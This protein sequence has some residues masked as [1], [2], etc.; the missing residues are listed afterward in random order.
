MPQ[1]RTNFSRTADK[2][3]MSA[4]LSGVPIGVHAPI[5]VEL[6]S[7]NRYAVLCMLLLTD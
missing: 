7:F 2:I 3:G 5:F 4:S 6:T 1:V